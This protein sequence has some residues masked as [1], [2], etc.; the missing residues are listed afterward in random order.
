MSAGI[1]VK[2]YEAS[3]KVLFEKAMAQGQTYTVP[4]DAQ[5]PLIWTGRPD[6]LAIT[7]AGKP[8]AKLS[9]T[10]RTIKGVPISAA[11]LLARAP[12]PAGQAPVSGAASGAAKAPP[13]AQ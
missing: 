6:A 1:W 12:A 9:E 2:V 5:A 7:V 4:A 8:V 13:A 3:G 11:A 10:Q